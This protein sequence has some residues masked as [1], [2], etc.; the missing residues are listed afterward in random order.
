MNRKTKGSYIIKLIPKRLPVLTE[1]PETLPPEYIKSIVGEDY[2]SGVAHPQLRVKFPG[3]SVIQN[4]YRTLLELP[5]NEWATRLHNVLAGNIRG[6]AFL[7]FVENN[8]PRPMTEDEACDV[9]ETIERLYAIDV[10]VSE[11]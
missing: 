3:L 10:E 6:T 5:V 2:V 4:T 9:R 7:A 11:E 8:S 1:A